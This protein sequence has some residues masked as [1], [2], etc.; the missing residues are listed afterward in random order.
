[1]G[2]AGEFVI[3]GKVDNFGSAGYRLY[4][5]LTQLSEKGVCIVLQLVTLNLEHP[6]SNR[7]CVLS[8]F[9]CIILIRRFLLFL[10]FFRAVV[11]LFV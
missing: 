4:V 8:Y 3:V 6:V 2:V 5:F 1:M 10:F 9:F 7:H 11:I